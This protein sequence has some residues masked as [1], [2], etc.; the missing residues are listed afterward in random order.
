MFSLF[1]IAAITEQWFNYTSDISSVVGPAS[2]KMYVAP[3]CFIYYNIL[4]YDLVIAIIYLFIRISHSLPAWLIYNLFQ[5]WQSFQTPSP[6]TACSCFSQWSLISARR[7]SHSRLPATCLAKRSKPMLTQEICLTPVV[8]CFK[9]FSP[10]YIL[11][12]PLNA[13]SMR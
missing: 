7:T 9:S 4:F 10:W 5:A 11:R 1:L 2:Y 13:A 12:T 3:S 6:T 8:S